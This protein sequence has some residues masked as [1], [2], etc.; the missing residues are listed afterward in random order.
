MFVMTQAKGCKDQLGCSSWKNLN[1]IV[2]QNGIDIGLLE[3]AG[4]I[5]G[6]QLLKRMSM[7]NAYLHSRYRL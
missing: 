6:E 2:C 4:V 5:L 3:F 1:N 7:Q